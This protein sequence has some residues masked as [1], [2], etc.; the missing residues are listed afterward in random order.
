[1]GGG[2]GSPSFTTPKDPSP[3][4]LPILGREEDEAKKRVASRNRNIGRE[5][6]RFAGLLNTRRN[7]SG[8]LNTTGTKDTLG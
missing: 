7:Q 5:S 4:P 3:T 8:I 6:T 1:M 2:S